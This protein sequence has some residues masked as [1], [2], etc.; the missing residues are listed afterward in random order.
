MSFEERTVI[1]LADSVLPTDSFGGK[2]LGRPLCLMP[3]I[4]Y[5]IE[6][7]VHARV[8]EILESGHEGIAA[9]C[10]ATVGRH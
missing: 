10:S 2:R 6:S 5:E 1:S 8:G 9:L 4:F 3:P 7:K